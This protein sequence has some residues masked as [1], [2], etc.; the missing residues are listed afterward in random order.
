MDDY[1]AS[2]ERLRKDAEEAAAIRDRATDPEKI[3]VDHRLHQH[4]LLLASE[5]EKAILQRIQPR[6]ELNK[7]QSAYRHN[8]EEHLPLFRPADSGIDRSLN[9]GRDR[10]E[11]PNEHDR[12]R[13]EPGSNKRGEGGEGR[14][15][16]LGSRE[17]H[18]GA[19]DEGRS[20]HV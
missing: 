9:V 13:T 2:L 7:D 3:A 14:A 19:E 8:G 17:E 15:V 5:I 10:P 4:Y 1:R 20:L 18:G 12:I 11:G 16:P 6:A